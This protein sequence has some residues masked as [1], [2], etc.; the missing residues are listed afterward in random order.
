MRNIQ[1]PQERLG[2]VS[3]NDDRVL[4]EN[5]SSVKGNTKTTLQVSR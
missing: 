2:L 3:A 5:V 1:E 4:D